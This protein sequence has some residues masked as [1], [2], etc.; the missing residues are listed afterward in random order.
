[1]HS[2]KVARRH[3]ERNFRVEILPNP[4]GGVN[5]HL[6]RNEAYVVGI[7]PQTAL[8]YTLPRQGRH[9]ENPESVWRCLRK[10]EDQDAF[11]EKS[12]SVLALGLLHL[13]I[14]FS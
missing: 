5:T 6:W 10:E 11:S 12:N 2:A 1:M 3:E 7:V 13:T 4:F 9:L 14:S 8:F